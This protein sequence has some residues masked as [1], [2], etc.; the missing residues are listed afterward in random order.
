MKTLSLKKHLKKL[1]EQ[2][3]K[4]L[5]PIV[6]K[7]FKLLNEEKKKHKKRSDLLEVIKNFSKFLGIP[8]DKSLYLLELYLL[9]YRKDGDY[10]SLTKTNFVDPRFSKGKITSNNKADLYTKAQLPFRGSNL[11]GY[12]RKDLNGDQYYKVMSYN[13]YPIYIFKHDKWYETTKRYSSSTSKQMFRSNPVEW[14][15]DLS[16]NVYLLS[17]EEMRMLEKGFSHEDIMKEKLR[18]I[19][20][21]EPD[22]K[23]ERMSTT[24][25][26]SFFD[27]DETRRIPETNIKF[28]VN[29]IDLEGDKAVVTID[30]YDVVKRERG[31]QVPTPQN[32][33]KGEIPNL[34]PQK[35]ED[36]IKIHMRHKLKDYVGTR[37][38]YND[39]TPLNT[40]IDF[41]FNHLKK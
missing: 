29:S 17:P 39:E 10:S 33:L 36:K 41:K 26:Y 7:L 20:S 16:E 28:K 8:E 15:S 35:V 24:K 18:K 2:S 27:T 19:K 3:E 12:W 22:M 9:N 31:K 32:Y 25:I 23:K 14:N 11:E 40:L 38:N 5:E 6:I 21:L 37:F 34:T 30:V 1:F 4:A 13:W